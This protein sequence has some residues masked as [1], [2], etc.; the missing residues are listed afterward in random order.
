MEPEGSLPCSQVPSTALYPELDHSSLYHSSHLSKIHFNV[1]NQLTSWSSQWSLSLWLSHQCPTCIFL[2]PIVLYVLLISSNYTWRRVQVMKFK[3]ICLFPL[4]NATPWRRDGETYRGPH[5]NHLA[6][7]KL[8]AW[9]WR[10]DLYSRSSRFVYWPKQGLSCLQF[11]ASFLCLFRTKGAS[12]EILC[13]SSI[14]LRF[15]SLQV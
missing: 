4:V 7:S 3:Y 6:I 11:T 2:L 15:D 10:L 12:F 13:N 8:F 1:V 9:L 5:I 14:I